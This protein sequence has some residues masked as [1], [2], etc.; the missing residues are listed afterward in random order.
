LQSAEV[1]VEDYN[2]AFYSHSFDGG[3]LGNKICIRFKGDTIEVRGLAVEACYTP[4]THY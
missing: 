3:V 4:G 1:E 2:W